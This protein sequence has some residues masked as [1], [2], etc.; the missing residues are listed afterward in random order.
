VTLPVI[1]V[2]IPFSEKIQTILLE[3]VIKR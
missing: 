3:G 2:S 1:V